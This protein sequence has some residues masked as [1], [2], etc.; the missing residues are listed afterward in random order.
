[1]SRIDFEYCISSNR[2]HPRIV[3]TVTIHGT[4]THTGIIS[5]DSHW[6]SVRAVCVIQLVSMADIRTER[7]CLL[8][9]VYDSHHMYLIQPSLMSAGFP[10][11]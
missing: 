9:K 3:A 5:D 10:K 4:R 11:K 6:A 8:L 7:L 1:M 2:R